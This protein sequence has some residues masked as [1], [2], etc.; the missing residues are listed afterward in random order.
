MDNIEIYKEKINIALKKFLDKKS[1]PVFLTLIA[2]SRFGIYYSAELKHYS[3]EM[4]ATIIILIFAVKIYE[5][6]YSFY[7]QF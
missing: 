6:E 3:L 4:L 7:L 5:S 1:L 2:F